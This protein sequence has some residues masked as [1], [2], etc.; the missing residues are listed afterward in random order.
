MNFINFVAAAG[1]ALTAATT[2]VL[3]QDRHDQDSDRRGDHTRNNDARQ[4][5]EIARREAVAA[6]AQAKRDCAR[7]ARA[8]RAHCLRAAKADYDHQLAD[9]RRR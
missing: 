6:Y 2:P 8:E 1:L 9:A 3:A 7:E 4:S 5:P